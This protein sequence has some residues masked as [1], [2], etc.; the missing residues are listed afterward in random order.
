MCVKKF[1]LVVMGGWVK[2]VQ[3]HNRAV[4]KATGNLQNSKEEVQNFKLVGSTI[5]VLRAICILNPEPSNSFKTG[6]GF[7]SAPVAVV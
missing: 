7:P 3:T 5:V 6:K 4:H 1:P 2:R